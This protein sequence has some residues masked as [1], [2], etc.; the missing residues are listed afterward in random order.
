LERRAEGRGGWNS[1]ME[2]LNLLDL[3]NLTLQV[4]HSL[5][6]LFPHLALNAPQ[7]FEATPAIQGNPPLPIFAYGDI[8]LH[9][10]WNAPL[11]EE[12][13]YENAVYWDSRHHPTLPFNDNYSLPYPANGELQSG[14]SQRVPEEPHNSTTCYYIPTERNSPIEGNTCHT[15]HEFPL[16]ET[17][18]ED[19]EK[20]IICSDHS[21]E[22]NL[23]AVNDLLNDSNNSNF[24][25][26][27]WTWNR[28]SSHPII[29]KEELPYDMFVHVGEADTLSTAERTV[30]QRTPSHGSQNKASN[31]ISSPTFAQQDGKNKEEHKKD[32]SH[33]AFSHCS[34]ASNG[35]GRKR[36]TEEKKKKRSPWGRENFFYLFFKS[37]DPCHNTVTSYGMDESR[38]GSRKRKKKGLIWLA[39]TYLLILRKF[40]R[41]KRKKKQ[42][43]CLP[44][45]GTHDTPSLRG[46]ED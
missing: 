11:T 42:S 33:R 45:T 25:W 17:S 7:C 26:K 31:N 30:Q 46:L 24:N 21:I 28:E 36:R 41:K 29:S 18:Y 22:S 13:S 39:S 38:R 14:W 4:S 10:A 43:N 1:T 35:K 8:H 6:Q 44:V 5:T 32:N 12:A 19:P 3:Y 27:S 23:S 20:N 9:Y 16:V 40:S 15:I 34:T 2:N 37:T